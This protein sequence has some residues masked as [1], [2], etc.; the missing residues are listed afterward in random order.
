[1]TVGG[2]AAVEAARGRVGTTLEAARRV[3][4]GRLIVGRSS[5]EV[6][7]A[8]DV[9]F[10]AAAR[11]GRS[12]LVREA[13]DAATGW[14]TRS[15]SERA[16]SGTWAVTEM[17]MSVARAT[18]R[19]SLAEA[20]ADAVTADAIEDLVAHDTTDALRARWSTLVDAGSI[21]DPGSLS[22]IASALTGGSSSVSVAIVILAIGLGV[23]LTGTVL[24]VALFAAVALLLR[25]AFARR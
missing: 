25:A 2:E 8:R 24:G 18:D 1:M 7:R 5:P 13:R 20:L 11:A 22:G 15:F 4:L 19:A 16:Y 17:S 6:D 12:E 9:A 23:V 21:P 3:E 14:V 10:D